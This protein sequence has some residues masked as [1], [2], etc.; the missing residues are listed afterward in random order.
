MIPTEF[1]VCRLFSRVLWR[2]DH[3]NLWPGTFQQ[4]SVGMLYLLI[5]G[6]MDCHLWRPSLFLWRLGQIYPL[7]SLAG[8]FAHCCIM[9]VF[10]EGPLVSTPIP[11]L[12]FVCPVGLHLWIFTT[13]II[14]RLHETHA[15]KIAMSTDTTRI[16]NWTQALFWQEFS[17]NLYCTTL[18]ISLNH[19]NIFT[20]QQ[21]CTPW[22]PFAL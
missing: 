1:L 11:K 13:I 16:S 15:K 12:H 6:L 7:T 17:W 19:M 21:I 2:G 18:Q 10:A 14:A 5:M 20:I 4:I 3:P 8:Q 22:W 9:T